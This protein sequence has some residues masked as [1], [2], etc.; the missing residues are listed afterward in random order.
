MNL[1]AV[2]KP[3]L[4][5]VG[6]ERVG[7]EN[8][9]SRTNH[10]LVGEVSEPCRLPVLNLHARYAMF[11]NLASSSRVSNCKIYYKIVQNTSENTEYEIPKS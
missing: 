4:P 5:I 6:K 9:A 11:P 1:G 3:R 2:R 8:R 10:P 7:L